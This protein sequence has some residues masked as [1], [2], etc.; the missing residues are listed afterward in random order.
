MFVYILRFLG[1]TS[2]GKGRTGKREAAWALVA[3]ALGLTIAGMV[4][5]AEIMQAM[6]SVLIILWP[7]AILAVAGAYKLE[8]DKALMEIARRDGDAE[9][10]QTDT[11]QGKL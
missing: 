2:T 7:S 1:V 10:D 5:G 8:H 3:I 4:M 6:D 9:V 11:Y